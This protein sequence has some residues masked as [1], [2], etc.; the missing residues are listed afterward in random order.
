MLPGTV[1]DGQRLKKSGDLIAED[2]GAVVRIVVFNILFNISQ[3]TMPEVA[4]AEEAMSLI[5]SGINR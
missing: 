4:R 2:I 1:R 5:S 3:H